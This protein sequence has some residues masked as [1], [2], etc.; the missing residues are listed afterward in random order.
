MY[1]AD[2][3]DRAR[4]TLRNTIILGP[5]ALLSSPLSLAGTLVHEEFH[6][7]QNP[8][9]KTRSFWLGVFNRQHPMAR[10]EWPAYHCQIRFLIN[11]S[12]LLPDMNDQCINEAKLVLLSYISHYGEP[13]FDRAGWDSVKTLL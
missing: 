6:T 12:Q 3:P 13:I 7:R 1:H 8:F 5:E 9:H 10:Y 2:L 4:V 11:L